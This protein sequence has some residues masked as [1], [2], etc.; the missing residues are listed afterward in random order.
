MTRDTKRHFIE[1]ETHWANNMNIIK[2]EYYMNSVNIFRE[3][4][5]KEGTTVAKTSR[6]IRESSVVGVERTKIK[7]IRK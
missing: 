4:V 6:N 1:E 2:Y 5:R 3:S 7:V